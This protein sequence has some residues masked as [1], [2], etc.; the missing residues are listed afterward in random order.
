MLGVM[1]ARKD[2]L[3]FREFYRYRAFYCGLCGTMG[4]RCGVVS[5]LALSYEMTFLA[6]LLTALYEPETAEEKHRCLVHPIGRQKML[7]NSAIDYCADLSAMLSYYDLRDGWE[8]ERRVE[9]LAGSSLLA[10]AAEAGGSRWPR[11]YGAVREY[12]EKLHEVE[13]RKDPVLDTA[14][15]LTGD[16]LGELYVW[17]ED[18]YSTDLRTLGFG[19]GKFIYLLD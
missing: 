9:Q 5:R 2:E 11:Q 15:N 17:Q 18:I 3:R 16:L 19:V 1:L 8:D 13:Q 7:R 6:M 14:A 12:V 10:G 4:K